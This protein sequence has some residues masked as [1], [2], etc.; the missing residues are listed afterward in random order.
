[1][2]ILKSGEVYVNAARGIGGL[3][4]KESKG[5][6][7]SEEMRGDETER[8]GEKRSIY[9]TCFEVS[10]VYIVH[11]LRLLNDHRMA[12]WR[13]HMLSIDTEFGRKSGIGIGIR[14]GLC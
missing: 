4:G 8:D 11:S 7:G 5:H 10:P 13:P 9:S 3:E 6:I 1:M 2:R 14:S 12:A